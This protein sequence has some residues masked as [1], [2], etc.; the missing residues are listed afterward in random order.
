MN[1]E[2]TLSE[3]EQTLTR[4]L[5][6]PIKQPLAPLFRKLKINGFGF[7]KALAKLG[8]NAYIGRVTSLPADILD[9]FDAIKLVELKPEERA[10][11][12]ICKA[13]LS[14]A[15]DLVQPIF[16]RLNS[17]ESGND[18][19]VNNL[20]AILMEGE[21]T[22][23]LDFFENPQ[24][25]AILREFQNS[26][27]QWLTDWGLE[28]SR[29]KTVVE[30]LPIFFVAALHREWSAHP[31]DYA[32]IA[33]ALNSPFV[34]KTESLREWAQYYALLRKQVQ[35]DMFGET[36]SLAQIYVPL[37]AYYERKTGDSQPKSW[38]RPGRD[39]SSPEADLVERMV[40]P[41]EDHLNEWLENSD[42][43]DSLRIISGGPGSGKSSS[44]KIWAA[45]LT[46]HSDIRVL[47]I[48]LHYFDLRSELNQSVGDFAR[49]SAQLSH[50]PLDDIKEAKRLLLIFDGL[51][52]IASQGR[53]SLELSRDFMAEITHMLSQR[54]QTECK[55]QALITGR[56]FVIQTNST[57]YR[58]PGQV[59]HALPYRASAKNYVT[60]MQIRVMDGNLLE[61]P[62]IYQDPH[63]LMEEDQRD[64]WWQNYGKAIGK[65]YNRMPAPLRRDDLEDI[66]TQPLLNYLIAL[67]YGRGHLNFESSSINLNQIYEDLLSG[68]HE[69]K[70]EN[71]G[72][73]HVPE[74]ESHEFT[75]ALE[76]IALAVWHGNGRTA[77]VEDIEKHC[78]RSGMT[79]LIKKMEEGAKTGVTRLIM[80]FYFREKNKDVS[81]NSTFEFTHKS[82]GEY[83]TAKRIVTAVDE[84]VYNLKEDRKKLRKRWDEADALKEWAETCGATRL[85]PYV[86]DFLQREILLKS[87]DTLA[88]WQ[89]ELC[90]LIN[91]LLAEGLPLEDVK[92]ISTF[93]EMLYYSRNAEE[94]LLV[95]HHL[96]AS[97]VG[98]VKPSPIQWPTDNSA[99][100]WLRRLQGNDADSTV[101][102][103]LSFLSFE[104]QRFSKYDFSEAVLTEVSFEKSE[105]IF[106]NFAGAYLDDTN[107]LG[108]N[109]IGANLRGANLEGANL[110]N[111]DLSEADLRTA[112]LSGVNLSHANLNDAN[113][114][115]VDLSGVNLSY[116]NLNDAD[117][118]NAVLSKVI[119]R[120][121]DLSSANLSNADLTFSDLHSA[122]LSFAKLSFANLNG[123]DLSSAD[124]RN[125]DLNTIH[126]GDV[127]LSFADLSGA[128]LRGADLRSANLNNTDLRD[129]ELTGADLGKDHGAILN[130]HED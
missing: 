129:A 31:T 119:L 104:G 18:A 99:G 51:D 67:S 126:F 127:N 91:F 1:T 12:L 74:L 125:A 88:E 65:S 64:L 117:L 79:G 108:A 30:R 115:G 55:V 105:M 20:D 47:Y 49:R 63:N 94:A 6:L 11:L 85:D 80:A 9:A 73:I 29:A 89:N 38:V 107:F 68:V 56:E 70:Y 69:R 25:L 48:P 8:G 75:R 24:N 17:E 33:T 7:I 98:D 3:E 81:G 37:R 71:K 93:K 10:G 61:R 121:A 36:F 83:L 27:F 58:L 66:T 40:V 34:E 114:S 50:N 62:F 53:A 5:S 124:L 110:E 96:C 97:N 100:E 118:S 82:F 4:S 86:T 112:N 41:L 76:E 14:G 15:A 26:I 102:D 111:V 42:P 28:E 44:T 106:C 103:Y 32:A 95:I 59:L 109:L 84:I 92:E 22:I 78:E 46:G 116:A 35:D 101:M 13:M 90:K 39:H 128:D 54:N 123:A 113:L 19:L 16:D 45:Q 87:Q 72:Q 23:D 122:D 52:E 21:L 120:N 57:F 60:L 2:I 130:P 77:T 43:K